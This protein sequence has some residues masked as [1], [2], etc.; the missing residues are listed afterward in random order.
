[1]CKLHPQYPGLLLFLGIL[2]W[3]GRALTHSCVGG[4]IVG[5]ALLCGGCGNKH[6]QEFVNITLEV[7]PCM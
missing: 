7:T 6:V 1:M 4:S 3:V 5:A 2:L